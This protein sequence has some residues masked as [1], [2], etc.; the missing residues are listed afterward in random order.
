MLRAGDPRA[1]DAYEAHGRII[2]GTLDEH[3]DRDRHRLGRPSPAT[4]TRW[5]SS[6][7]TND[8]VD[9]LNAAVQNRRLVAGDLDPDTAV[10]IAGGEHRPR[11]GRGRHPTQRP[12]ADHH[13]R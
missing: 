10:A 7:S 13:R 9:L 1:L 6:P 4:G 11:R 8:H 3:L 2:P 12:A 5:R